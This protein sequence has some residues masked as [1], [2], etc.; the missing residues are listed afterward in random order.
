MLVLFV[1]DIIILR[2]K[3]T[4]KLNVFSKCNF[5][6]YSAP[7]K[8]IPN[9]FFESYFFYLDNKWV[10]IWSVCLSSWLARWMMSWLLTKASD[11]NW[12]R[13]NSNWL[14]NDI[15]QCTNKQ[16]LNILHKAQVHTSHYYS[17]S[18]WI[19]IQTSVSNNCSGTAR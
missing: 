11:L 14:D 16:N 10:W 4:K 6:V 3:M 8:I 15:G 2:S 9:F 1:L 13:K 7:S 5:Q 19:E 18:I 12:E 17:V